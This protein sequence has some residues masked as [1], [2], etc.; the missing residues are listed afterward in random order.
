MGSKKTGRKIPPPR[1]KISRRHQPAVRNLPSRCSR[2]STSVCSCCRADVGH[3]K[4]NRLGQIWIRQADIHSQR[5]LVVG[6]RVLGRSRPF[7]A[8]DFDQKAT[9]L[10]SGLYGS[11]IV[12]TIKF[13]NLAIWGNCHP[14]TAGW[15]QRDFVSSINDAQAFKAVAVRSFC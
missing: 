15:S 7:I 5:G 12:W 11:R 6:E 13:Y 10:A 2:S 4:L 9:V 1:M 3:L 8:V 14:L